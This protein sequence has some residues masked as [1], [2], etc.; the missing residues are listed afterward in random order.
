MMPYTDN[1]IFDHALYE[2]QRERMIDKF[3]KCAHCGE[4]ITDDHLFDIDGELYH[5]SCAEREFQKFTDDYID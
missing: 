4:P 5:L 2:A 3:P 1:P